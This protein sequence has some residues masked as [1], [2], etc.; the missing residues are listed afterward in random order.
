MLAARARRRE[1]ED[2]PG[3]LVSLIPSP[4][5][6]LDDLADIDDLDDPDPKA[7]GSGGPMRW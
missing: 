6:P 2:Q 3:E 5:S 4:R 7:G 1:G